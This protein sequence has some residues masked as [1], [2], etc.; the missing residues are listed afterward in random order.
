MFAEGEV[1]RVKVPLMSLEDEEWNGEVV[2][3]RIVN[4]P[5]DGRV[6]WNLK[7]SQK[8]RI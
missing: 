8:K 2:L 4:D 3:E 7:A 1:A 6:V 5:E